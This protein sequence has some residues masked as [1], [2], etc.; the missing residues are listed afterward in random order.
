MADCKHDKIERFE[1]DKVDYWYCMGCKSV[2]H[3]IF[4]N[5]NTIKDTG[6]FWAVAKRRFEDGKKDTVEGSK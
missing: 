4:V 6:I 5:E 3:P 2:V 1:Y